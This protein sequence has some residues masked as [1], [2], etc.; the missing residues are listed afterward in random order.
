MSNS[1]RNAGLLWRRGTRFRTRSTEHCQELTKKKKD[2]VDCGDV[3]QM[4]RDELALLYFTVPQTWRREFRSMFYACR[5]LLYTSM[6]YTRQLLLPCL[7]INAVEWLAQVNSAPSKLRQM[8]RQVSARP[9]LAVGRQKMS[10]KSVVESQC[11]D[12]LS[13]LVLTMC[14]WVIVN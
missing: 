10:F 3:I 4:D 6:Q 9:A 7:L 1:R 8:S 11:L 5:T 14:L 12:S 13:M 2:V